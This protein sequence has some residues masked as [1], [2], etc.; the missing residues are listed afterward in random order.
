MEWVLCHWQAIPIDLNTFVFYLL[1]F[2]LY[3]HNHR[4][5]VFNHVI[6]FPLYQF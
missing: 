3:I 6:I 5:L 1:L 4:I 2:N